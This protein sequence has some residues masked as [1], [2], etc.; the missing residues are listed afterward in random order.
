VRRRRTVSRKSAR[1]RPGKTTKPKRNSPRAARQGRSSVANLQEKL[2]TRTRQLNEAIEREKATAEV[3]KV[4]S[5]SP[6]DLAPVFQS[7]LE[8]ATR[9][10]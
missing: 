3:L 9:I 10:C 5:S 4:I 1:T 2:D 6:G 7:M 8:Q